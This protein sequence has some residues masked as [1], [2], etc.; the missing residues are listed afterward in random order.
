MKHS[1]S[2]VSD[3]TLHRVEKEDLP[4]VVEFSIS[5]NYEHY[6]DSIEKDFFTKDVKN[7]LNKEFA[8]F[9]SAIYYAILYKS[10]IVG[11]IRTMEWDKKYSNNDNTTY[12]HVGRFAIDNKVYARLNIPYIRNRG[13][14]KNIL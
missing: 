10:E 4:K 3:L 14:F 8:Y 12:W 6:K 2:I 5:T 11:S 7:A 9:N 1:K 13:R